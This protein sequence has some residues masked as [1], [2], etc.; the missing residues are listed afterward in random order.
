[1]DDE[2]HHA[3]VGHH[4]PDPVGGKRG[5]PGD[6]QDRHRGPR[7]LRGTSGADNL[8]GKG[9]NDVLYA[10]AGKDNLLGGEGKDYV[11]GGNERRPFGGDKTLVGGPGNDGV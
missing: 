3:A 4:G 5:G 7:T 1:M 8:L 6:Q 9:G 11:L 10:L 2:T